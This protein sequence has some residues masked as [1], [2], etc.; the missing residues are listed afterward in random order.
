MWWV[1]LAELTD[2]DAVLPAVADTLQ[3][4]EATEEELIG[5]LAGRRLLLVIDN[6]EHLLDPV[7]RLVRRLLRSCPSLTILATSQEALGNPGE[8]VF[9][10]P[11]L[12][13]AVRLFVERAQAASYGFELTEANRADIDRI[14][15][16]LDGVPLAIELAAAWVPALSPA[17]TAVRLDDSL[18]VLTGGDREAMPRHRTL[19]GAL[20]WS[21][22]LL[23]SAE[24]SLLAQLS[25]FPAGFTVDA[26]EAVADLGDADVLQ[27]STATTH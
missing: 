19:R 2:P 3:L 14:C 16:R 21:W 5:K 10:V 8:V 6:C 15:E 1:G 18:R 11:P 17:Q 4:P 12:G 22:D 24:R 9:T 25:V 26:V 20:D 23:G 27:A 13:E 7:A